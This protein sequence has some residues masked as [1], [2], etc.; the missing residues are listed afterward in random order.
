M[1]HHNQMI[2]VLED[3]ISFYSFHAFRTFKNNIRLVFFR[4]EKKGMF[5]KSKIKLSHGNTLISCDNRFFH[6][7]SFIEYLL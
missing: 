7:A 4:R 6:I 5:I 3:Y 2:D 1:N